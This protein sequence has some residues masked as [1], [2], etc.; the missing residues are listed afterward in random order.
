MFPLMNCL[1]VLVR[2]EALNL[3]VVVAND[4]GKGGIGTEE[5]EVFILRRDS[6]A[7]EHV[8]GLKREI[9][10]VLIK[11]VAEMLNA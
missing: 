8:C 10:A 6:N 3:D 2:M 7:V 11:I 9:A 5:N 4:V 1:S